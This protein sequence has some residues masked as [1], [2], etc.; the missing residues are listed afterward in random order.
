M[1]TRE[2]PGWTSV[3]GL[4][5]VTALILVFGF[6]IGWLLDRLL[7]TT[8]IFIFV[9]LALGIAGAG[10]YIYLAIRNIFND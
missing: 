1:V 9:G 8:P 2:P 10:R 4:G 7:H 5:A 3:L 6:G